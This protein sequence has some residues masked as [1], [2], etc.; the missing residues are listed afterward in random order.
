MWREALVWAGSKTQ[1]LVWFFETIE[2]ILFLTNCGSSD[3][4]AISV[5]IYVS[6]L[7]INISMNV[8]YPHSIQVSSH[9][10]Y[11]FSKNLLRTTWVFLS[12]WWSL[13][14]ICGA[15][16]MINNLA[17]NAGDARDT[18]SIPGS[19]R[20]PGEGNG[21]ILQYSCLE[22]S[23]GQRSLA[24]YRRWGL[25][26]SDITEHTHIFTFSTCTRN[27]HDEQLYDLS[28]DSWLLVIR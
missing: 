7:V 23:Q 21:Y 9:T 3:L 18:G 4:L 16:Q 24:G 13:F 26:D 11:Y 2:N 6:F 14:S 12:I 8:L 15:S 19:R 22:K 25:N 1:R 27:L 10:T 17:A 28:R 5:G 20:P